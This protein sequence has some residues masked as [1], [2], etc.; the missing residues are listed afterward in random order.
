MSVNLFE[1]YILPRASRYTNSL[2]PNDILPIPWGDLTTGGSKG[3]WKCPCINKDDGSGKAVYAIA[4]T[5]ILSVANGNVI[6]VYLNGEEITGGYTVTTAG[7]YESQ[8]S[9]AY[10]EV[11]STIDSPREGGNSGSP[12]DLVAT[13]GGIFTGNANK[14]YKIIITTGG[15][16]GAAQCTIKELWAFDPSG[17]DSVAN[18][19]TITSGVALNLGTK[20]ATITFTWTGN[21]TVGD[22]WTVFCRTSGIGF[23]DISVRCKGR[24]SG[25][26]LIENPIS[27]AEDFLTNLVGMASAD[28]DATTLATTKL[29]CSDKD[30]QAAGLLDADQSPEKTVKELL[31]SYLGRAHFNPDGKYIFTLDT[32]S[33]IYDPMGYIPS[34]RVSNLRAR[35]KLADLLNQ[36]EVKYAYNYITNEFQEHDDG[37]TTKNSIS[38]GIYGMRKAEKELSWCRNLTDVNIIQQIL[39]LQT[40]EPFWEVEF[41]DKSMK[42]LAIQIGDYI[43]VTLSSLYDKEARQYDNQIFKILGHEININNKNISFTALDTGKFRGQQR[44][45]SVVAGLELSFANQIRL[46]GDRDTN[47]YEM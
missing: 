43:C 11:T 23:T 45:L 5:P 40:A 35:Q 39:L 7:D 46:S 38:Q 27:I 6:T 26:S 17:D 16:S 28:I 31:N 41:I 30:Y 9:I 47:I 18:P 33:T 34:H 15:A 37:S 12:A 4:G 21:L 14:T 8:G 1:D 24:A 10:I 22:N 3:V 44:F 20:G 36:F 32:D 29:F 2:N 13:S 25:G 19:Q 42:L